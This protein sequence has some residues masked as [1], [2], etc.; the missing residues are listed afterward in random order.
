[1]IRISYKALIELL[2]KR[3][4]KRSLDYVLY[5]V[6]SDIFKTSLRFAY[7]IDDRNYLAVMQSRYNEFNEQFDFFV[8]YDYNDG[9][10]VA[11]MTE[12]INSSSSISLPQ[13]ALICVEADLLDVEEF[14]EVIESISDPQTDIDTEEQKDKFRKYVDFYDNFHDD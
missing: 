13:F 9:R 7:D 8:G 14:V 11:L 2:E 6:G 4:A 12:K 1:M 5:E 10:K 3:Y